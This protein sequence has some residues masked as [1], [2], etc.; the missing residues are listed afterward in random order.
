MTILVE[1]KENIALFQ[2]LIAISFHI[3]CKK[4]VILK[5]NGRKLM[6]FKIVTHSLFVEWNK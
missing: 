2:Q 5:L 4:Y 1:E 3:K 6:I